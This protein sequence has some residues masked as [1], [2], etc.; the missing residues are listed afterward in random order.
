MALIPI[1]LSDVDMEKLCFICRKEMKNIDQVLLECIQERLSQ[2]D[3]K[4][5][6]N[7]LIDKSYKLLCE[8]SA[9]V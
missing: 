6:M 1:N 2:K 3:V 5:Y 4:A 7:E 8:E 9:D